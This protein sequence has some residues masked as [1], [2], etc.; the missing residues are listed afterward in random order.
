MKAKVE[1]PKKW[2]AETPNLYRLVVTLRDSTGKHLESRSTRIGFRK[3]EWGSDGLKVNGEEIILLGVNRHDHDPKTGKAINANRMLEDILL[4]KR[5]NI[6]AVRTSHYPNDVKFYELCDE[7]GL[8]VMDETN[9][10][11]HALGNY[12]SQRPDYAGQMLDRAIRMVERDKNHPSIIS[13]S[14]GN[15]AGTGPNHAAMAAWMKERDNSRFNHNEGAHLGTSD[16]DYIDIRSRMY[17][18]IE[19][20][21]ELSKLDERPILYCEYAHSMGNSTGHLY[22]FV[23]LFRKDPKIVGGFIWDWVDQGLYKTSPDGEQYFAY[24]GDFGEEYT[25]GAFCLNGLIFPDRTPQPALFECKKLFQPIE[26]A[27]ERNKLKVKN[28]HDFVDLSQ[29]QLIYSLVEDGKITKQ[30]SLKLPAIAPNAM[31][32]VSLPEFE[33]NNTSSYLLNISFQLKEKTNWA[34][35]NHEV[36]WFQFEL[37]EGRISSLARKSDV[38]ITKDDD[39]ELEVTNGN[40]KLT[41][42]KSNGW[43]KSYKKEGQELL[44]GSLRPNFWRAPT[45]NDLAWGMPKRSGAWKV[46]D[47]TATLTSFEKS[48]STVGNLVLIANYDLLDGKAKQTIRYEIGSNGA[49]HIKSSLTLNED[50]P[51]PVRFGSLFAI[52][53]GYERINYYGKGPHEAYVDRERSAKMG[54]YTQTVADWHTPYIRPQENGNRMGI[55]WATFTDKSGNGIRIEGKDLN[56]S[57]HTYTQSDLEVA[58]HTI[59]L[60]KRQFITVKVDA[61]QMGVGGDDTWTFNARPHDEHRLTAKKY[62]YNFTLLPEVPRPQRMEAM[63][64]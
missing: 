23:D 4:M 5:Y 13:W 41:F 27:Q 59:D 3:I 14:L 21:E 16:S 25:D 47:Q 43:L 34:D 39:T 62:E 17:T 53:A 6:N 46:A 20:M 22:K 40:T 32:M 58:K 7:Y 19:K 54:W 35:A 18:Q 51:E 9:I 15:E 24:G 63:K 11:T 33:L 45:D 42:T 55:K 26:V 2:T 57:A 31:E 29:Y 30:G 44:S 50:A 56:M 36:A 37:Q 10:E 49:L 61:A 28:L 52:P 12:I 64:E 1:N 48:Q 8:Y 60:P 38:S